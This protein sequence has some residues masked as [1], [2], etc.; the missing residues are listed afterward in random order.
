MMIC[1]KTDDLLPE[2]N[3]NRRFTSYVRHPDVRKRLGSSPLRVPLSFL[4]LSWRPLCLLLLTTVL[5]ACAGTVRVPTIV[6]VKVPIYCKATLP[7]YPVLPVGALTP[8][9][10]DAAVAKAYVATIV[11]LRNDDDEVR[12]LLFACT[13]P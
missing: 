10:S 7:P 12:G 4:R 1:A 3:I 5:V 2:S 9:S 13:K 8:T 11:L 6:R